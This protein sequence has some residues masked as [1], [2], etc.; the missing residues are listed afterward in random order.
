VTEL[1]GGFFWASAVRLSAP[2]FLAAIGETVVQRAGMFNIGIEGMMLIGAFAGVAGGVLTGSTVAGLALAVVVTAVFGCLYGV[3]VAGFRADQVV[4]GIGFNIVVLG[5]TSL[6]R[7]AWLTERIV[8]LSP[9]WLAP[10]RIPLLGGLPFAGRVLF[11]QSPVVYLAFAI[12]PAVAFFLFRTR[13][14]LLLRAV[15][16]QA[17]AAD[18][19]GI[20][21]VGIR[22]AAMTFGGVMAG[23]AGAYLSIVATSGVFID[24]MTL[25]RGFLAIAIT[26]F[27]RWRPYRVALAALLFGAAEALQFSSQAVFGGS[28]SPP[29]L[30]AIPFVLAIIAW[31]V[32]G[33]GSAAPGDLG[34]P[35]MRTER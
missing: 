29:L 23:L 13:P 22:I 31:A 24:N 5:G 18:S 15:G 32:M 6:L 27:G 11:D 17:T 20:P 34:R 25:G 10:H 14:G 9:G 4:T 8:S 16:E 33:R 3:L 35:F 7:S 28:V 19:A 26:I 21:V 2:M 1:L 12:L 30:L